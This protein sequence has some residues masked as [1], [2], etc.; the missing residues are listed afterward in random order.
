M[1][2]LCNV[3]VQSAIFSRYINVDP[4]FPSYVLLSIFQL[5]MCSV[6]HCPLVIVCREKRLDVEHGLPNVLTEAV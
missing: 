2:S 5:G 1:T 4:H 6:F 3:K